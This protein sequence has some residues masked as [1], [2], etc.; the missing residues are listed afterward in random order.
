MLRVKEDGKSFLKMES[1]VYWRWKVLYVQRFPFFSFFKL[2]PV[3]R[4]EKI[5][6]KLNA[7][8]ERRWKVFLKDR[9]PHILKPDPSKRIIKRIMHW[10]IYRRLAVLNRPLKLL[11]FSNRPTF[12][13]IQ[14]PLNIQISYPFPSLS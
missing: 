7:K 9:K 10:N 13:Y 4:I 8:I 5:N 1:L 11:G 3:S 12:F 2:H 6:K 14:S